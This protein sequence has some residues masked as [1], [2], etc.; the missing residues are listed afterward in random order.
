MGIRTNEVTSEGPGMHQNKILASSS[1]SRL[2]SIPKRLWKSRAKSQSRIAASNI[3]SWTPE[4]NC[5]WKT[6]TG[7]QV[8]LTSTNVLTLTEI[9]RLALQQVS[10]NKLKSL[11]LGFKIE[12]PKEESISH[13]KTKRRPKLLTKKSITTSFFEGKEK[14]EKEVPSE[15]LVFG[16]PI[17]QCLQ[18]ERLVKQ[19]SSAPSR[20]APDTPVASRSEEDVSSGRA[21]SND[22]VSETSASSLART[23]DSGSIESLSIAKHTCLDL[24]RLDIG[25]SDGWSQGST[26]SLYTNGPQ[27][28]AVV[29]ACF[30]HIETYGLHVLGIFRVSSSKKRLRQLRDD[31]DSG[32]EVK[33][34]DEHHPHDV[35][36]LLKE[37]F[38]DLPEPL[39]TRELYQAFLST[40][41][42]RLPIGRVEM[43]QL[44][45]NL[46]PVT[47]RDTLWALLNFLVKVA[48][49]SSDRLSENKEFLPGNKMDSH[50]LA[51]LF[52][53]N[54]LRMTKT[55]KDYE[56]LVENVSRVQE[57]C[58]VILVVKS[59]IDNNEKLFEVS[60]E[61][62]DAAYRRLLVD[63]PEALDVLL[64]R[65]YYSSPDYD[66]K[67][68]TLPNESPPI[69][70]KEEEN[71]LRQFLSKDRSRKREK[72]SKGKS[73]NDQG[74]KSLTR[75]LTLAEI[76]RAE[77]SST[78]MSN[79]PSESLDSPDVTTSFTV[80]VPLSRADR[81]PVIV[82]QLEI[83][84]ASEDENGERHK[85][86]GNRP[87]GKNRH[88]TSPSFHVS[89]INEEVTITIKMPRRKPKQE[90]PKTKTSEL[91]VDKVLPKSASTSI[92]SGLSLG[93]RD[94]KNSREEST[95]HTSTRI[96]PF[97]GMSSP[98][99]LRTRNV[100]SSATTNFPLE[101]WKRRE[102][103]A[104]EYTEQT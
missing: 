50:N 98:K 33:L 77:A 81:G 69:V 4:G 97:F 49:N 38:R 55:G 34:N 45:L 61:N 41:R 22:T 1:T 9:E 23:P 6:T 95:E 57:R 62:L 101:R 18:N 63:D 83:S 92:L 31:F 10:L 28:P 100:Q 73:S 96:L 70:S 72:K 56:F 32:K 17:C 85:K 12:V 90:D 88:P 37:Y 3:C 8:K 48:D 80:M 53:P 79:S 27:V 75:P 39:L 30:R 14:K 87:Y 59:L 68:S 64:R 26:N 67:S 20:E 93:H 94:K 52:G 60:A 7:H 89:D 13:H 25:S 78:E 44:L 5:S 15:G 42:P 103:I 24:G 104:S 35:A 58:D 11:S 19:R 65:R 102:I 66:D 29:T 54:I 43:L 46:L 99:P 51:T 71:Y 21:P 76:S 40:Q 16:I 91:D 86:G 2:V 74:R 84:E 36:Q 82:P 47:N